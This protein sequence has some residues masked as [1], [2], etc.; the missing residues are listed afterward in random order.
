M[1]GFK[2]LLDLRTKTIMDLYAEYTPPSEK[3]F[4]AGTIIVPI[5]Q[6]PYPITYVNKERDKPKPCFVA[7]VLREPF[8]NITTELMNTPRACE[9][10]DIVVGVWDSE[11]DRDVYFLA[12]SSHFKEASKLEVA[13]ASI[14]I[15]EL[16]A[17]S[18]AYHQDPFTPGTELEYRRKEFARTKYPEYG[19]SMVVLADGRFPTLDVVDRALFAT[20]GSQSASNWQMDIIRALVKLP[21][22]EPLAFTFNPLHF[23]RK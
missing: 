9:L 7:R 1:S 3:E 5:P 16:A 21:T 6:G 11:D 22:G 17:S 14:F 15:K 13:D 2:T 8:P 4:P 12:S 18:I 19:E 20:G 10:C 23:K